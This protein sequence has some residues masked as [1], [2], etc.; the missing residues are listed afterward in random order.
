M[1]INHWTPYQGFYLSHCCA[2][3]V[4][5]VSLGQKNLFLSVWASCCIC[6]KHFIP[7]LGLVRHKLHKFQTSKHNQNKRTTL[8]KCIKVHSTSDCQDEII[9]HS[10]RNNSLKPCLGFSAEELWASVMVKVS[11][12]LMPLSVEGFP[13]TTASQRGPWARASLLCCPLRPR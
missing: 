13:N 2:A 8:W 3:S 10:F 7:D 6:N 12:T 9:S 5:P 1:N 11:D 4:T